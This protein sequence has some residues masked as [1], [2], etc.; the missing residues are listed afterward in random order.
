VKSVNFE[1]RKA[2]VNAL[3][4]TGKPVYYQYA[5]PDAPECY[6]IL[7]NVTNSDNS[8]MNS[9]DTVTTMQIKIH[10]YS[11]KDNGGAL[12]DTVANT[13]LQAIY[14]N[15]QSNLSLSGFQITNTTLINDI[16]D[17]WQ[18]VSQRVY[19]DRIIT[20]RHTIFQK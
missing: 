10:T 17:T 14:A 16:I 2:Y 4:A 18:D 20:F 5:P 9:N 1:L 19:I 12:A 3:R 15:K 6:I 7:Q 11:D 8:T 13:A